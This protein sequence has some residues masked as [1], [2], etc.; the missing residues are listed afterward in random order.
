M[1]AAR[2]LSA[3]LIATL[4]FASTLAGLWA[5]TSTRGVPE[6]ILSIWCPV[7]EPA[8]P[9]PS[10]I[11]AAPDPD[12]RPVWW[13]EAAARAWEPPCATVQPTYAACGAAALLDG[14][15][16]NETGVLQVAVG[17][18]SHPLPVAETY[19][20][21]QP[22]GGPGTTLT[23]SLGASDDVV[24]FED[25]GRVGVVDDGDGIVVTTLE[26]EA[27]FEMSLHLRGWRVAQNGRCL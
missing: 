24:S 25:R 10:D 13:D 12:S 23:G 1:R 15:W 5:L 2:V 6:P 8:K 4:F 21:I 9:T 7:R 16:S 11:P 19:Y 14:A 22:W 3:G 18:T 17:R 26:P 20:V 27:A